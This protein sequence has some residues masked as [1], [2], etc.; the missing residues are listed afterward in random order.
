MKYAKGRRGWDEV[1]PPSC[2]SQSELEDLSGLNF[3]VLYEGFTLSTKD[4][5]VSWLRSRLFSTS[6]FFYFSERT[7]P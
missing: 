7:T 2:P 4:I 1:V 5:T 3:V 6:L